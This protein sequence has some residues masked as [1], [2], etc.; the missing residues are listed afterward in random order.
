MSIKPK[1]II[2]K[3]VREI[4][5]GKGIWLNNLK[6]KEVYEA[7]EKVR[8]EYDIS[9]KE[10]N[11]FK[12]DNPNH[13]ISYR[14]SDK[15]KTPIL[16]IKNKTI[17]DMY[18]IDDKVQIEL[19][20]DTIKIKISDS[21][22]EEEFKTYTK[23]LTYFEL[24]CGGGT[25][26][27]MFTQN[28]FTCVGGLEYTEKYMN[29]FK[30]NNKNNIT[31]ISSDLRDARPIMY[32]KYVSTLAA[33]IPCTTLSGANVNMKKAESCIMNNEGTE[34]QLKLV[35]T[36]KELNLLTFNVI[37]AVRAMTPRTVIIEEVVEYSRT[38]A[39]DML[40]NILPLFGYN[41]SEV[42]S[43]GSHSKRSRWCLVANMNN[44]INL[45][46]LIV[47][48]GLKLEDV[49]DLK[50]DEREWKHK[51]DIQRLKT[52][53]S[54]SSKGIGIR[55]SYPSDTMC[56]TFTT[57][58]TRHTEPCLKHPT[59]DKYSEFTNEDI[60]NIHGLKDFKLSGAK[61]ID[62]QILGQGVTDMFSEIAKRIKLD[63]NL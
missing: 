28:G 34:E 58:A 17:S 63:R 57:N 42:V 53:D 13:T 20:T 32:P 44:E 36:K 11:I 27:N 9:K 50:T 6:L 43:T 39:C 62:R 54:K 23:D 31:N 7:G 59:E 30:E 10:I 19:Y 49:I 22:T 1:N 3:N 25:M 29:V 61:S 48:N 26:T 45:D 46:N 52:A 4:G 51:D 55:Y 24:F 14:K 21:Q 56:N 60:S 8:I 41:I 16:D 37:E 47:D 33:G 12:S 40:R 38:D 18:T 2:I 35:E 15:N 5:K